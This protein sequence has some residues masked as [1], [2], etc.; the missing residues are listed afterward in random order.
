MKK[1]NLNLMLLVV[2]FLLLI[3]I[4]VSYFIFSKNMVETFS[5]MIIAILSVCIKITTKSPFINF[6]DC[7]VVWKLKS[8][9]MHVSLNFAFVSIAILFWALFNNLP[10][11]FIISSN[12]L[13]L[14]LIIGTLFY[15]SAI[16]ALHKFKL[17]LP[18]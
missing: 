6:E 2:V 7:S 17:I 13:N 16:I 14:L 4:L 9:I 12:V 11:V 3:E 5:S 15:C 18:I 1:I 8:F 10:N